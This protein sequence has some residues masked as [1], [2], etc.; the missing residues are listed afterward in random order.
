L[1]KMTT[2]ITTTTRRPSTSKLKLD[3][4]A[5]ETRFERVLVRNDGRIEFRRDGDVR[6]LVPR[7]SVPDDE[8]SWAGATGEFRT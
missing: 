8:G 4:D 5:R 3:D 1:K 2:A 6:Y 7:E